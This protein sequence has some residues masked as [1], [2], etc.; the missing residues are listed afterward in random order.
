MKSLANPLTFSARSI[1]I[2]QLR[3]IVEHGA[4]PVWKQ[5]KAVHLAPMQIHAAW[6]ELEL[7]LS[8]NK[9]NPCYGAEPELRNHELNVQA[10]V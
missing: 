3:L 4:Q 1:V 7:R 6:L 10:E 8:G 9:P 5:Y 2:Q